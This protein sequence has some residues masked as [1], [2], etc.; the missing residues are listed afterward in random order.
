MIEKDICVY[1]YAYLYTYV[2]NV[3]VC[4]YRE[5][6]EGKEEEGR[7]EGKGGRREREY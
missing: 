2:D 6:G 1:D 3:Y 4:I 5:V 7:M